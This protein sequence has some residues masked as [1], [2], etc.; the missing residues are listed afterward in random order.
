M[1]CSL[2]I[3]L[4]RL[5]ISICISCYRALV[6]SPDLVRAAMNFKKLSLTDIKVEIPRMP[7]KKQLADAVEAAGTDLHY[8]WLN[9]V[10]RH[11]PS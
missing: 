10:G 1:D 7:K 4:S 11:T 2:G 9:D 6:D 3:S 5:A 8:K